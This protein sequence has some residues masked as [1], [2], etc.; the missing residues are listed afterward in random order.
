MPEKKRSAAETD[1][2][3]KLA[4][5]RFAMAEEADH[6]QRQR[7]LAD[8]RF[9]ASDQWDPIARQ[10]RSGQPANASNGL[11]PV[12]ARPCLTINKVKEPVRQVLNSEREA[13]F[14][15][16][17]VAADDFGGLVE[18]DPNSANA[19]EI[20]LREGLVRRI[21]R[22]SEAADARSWAFNRATIAGRGY[23][24]IMTR[25]L[26]GKTWDQEICVHRY[27]NQASVTLDPAHEQPDGSDAEWGFVG[28]DMEWDAYKGEFPKA[29]ANARNTV[30]AC[31]DSEFRNLG[32]EMPGWFRMDGEIKMVR[33]VD[34]WYTEREQRELAMLPDGSAVFVDEIQDDAVKATIVDRRSVTEKKIQWCKIDGKQILDETEWAGPDLP[35]VKVLGEE[36]QPFDDK[37]AAI[38]MI[39]DSRDAQIGYNSIVSKWVETIGLAPIP[40]F[41]VAEGTVE[42]YGAWY[43]AAST[44]TLPYLPFK[45]TDLTGQPAPPPTRPSALDGSFIQALGASVQ[46]FNGAIRDTTG[47]PDIAQG[48]ADPSIT[49]GRQARLMVQQAQTGT[50]HYLDNLKRSM[51]YE[52]QIINNLLYP[53]YGTRPGRL[54]RIID[55]HGEASTVAIQ[56]PPPAPSAP[57]PN[58]GGNLTAGPQQP[59]APPMA[60]QPPMAPPAPAQY[61]LSKDANFNVIV[62][63]SRSFDSRRAEEA[64]TLGQVIQARPDLMNVFGDLYFKNQ[65]G[66]GHEQMAE[67]MRAMLAPPI[68]QMLSEASQGQS[69]SLPIDKAKIQQLQQQLDDAHK[70]L[71]ELA[72][73]EQSKQAELQSKIQIERMATDKEIRIQA[74][75]DATSI[76]VAEIAAGA[77]MGGGQDADAGQLETIALHTELAHEAS[78]NAMDRAHESAMAAQEHAQGQETAAQQAQQAQQVAAAQQPQSPNATP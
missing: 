74:M 31:S 42:Q 15:I 2:L 61:S 57:P 24:G 19:K 62:K 58:T 12:P 73:K 7:E 6:D 52:G 9:Y 11:P 10:E 20:E 8:L 77:K 34:Y 28:V 49:S 35:I 32:E 50:G 76:R 4:R 63:I 18:T 29:A 53:I 13:D 66:P 38:G 1:K 47:V 26:P 41:L 44:R 69:A 75:R 56:A 40:P 25:Y 67:R 64:D 30:L 48:K 37:R 59:S 46:L 3:L 22:E 27:Y 54:A 55:S 36:L 43:Q 60:G 21:Q 51:R 39:R 68:Q 23:Y 33:V 72:A 78:Q 16:E 65:D 5:D 17:I 45:T 70:I 14:G 71:Q